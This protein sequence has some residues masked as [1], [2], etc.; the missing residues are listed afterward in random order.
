MT[1]Y[2][3]ASSVTAVS[4]RLFLGS[5]VDAERMAK[6]NPHQIQTVITRCEES[7]KRR[8]A[9]IRCLEFPVHDAQPISIAL[10]N[11]IL[12]SIYQAVTE[13]AVLVHCHA[14]LS[15]VPILV[16]AFLDQSGSVRF[17]DAIRYLR[18]L[19]PEIA[20]SPNLIQSVTS[21]IVY[22]D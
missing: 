21:E 4:A 12:E 19:R 18:R 16:A 8:A 14:G 2:R 15:S 11:A 6:N 20:L 5:A 22:E 17:E 13:G 9:G 1:L 10:L 7:V 3:P